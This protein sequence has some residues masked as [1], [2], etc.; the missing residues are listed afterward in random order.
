LSERELDGVAAGA[1]APL[2]AVLLAPVVAQST[3]AVDIGYIATARSELQNAADRSSLAGFD[4][5]GR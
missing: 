5:P 1:V 4:G 3:S 2:M